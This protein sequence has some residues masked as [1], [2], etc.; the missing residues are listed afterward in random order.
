MQTIKSIAYRP[1]MGR[2]RTHTTW[3]N[4]LQDPEDIAR[5]VHWAL[6]RE[7]IHVIS[8]G[9]VSLLPHVLAAADRFSAAAAVCISVP[10]SKVL[11]KHR[12]PMPHCAR[13]W[14]QRHCPTCSWN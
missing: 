1:W 2:P 4:P 13:S 14:K 12:R 10:S 3:Y 9:D 8:V 7:G 5:A 6:G 11:E